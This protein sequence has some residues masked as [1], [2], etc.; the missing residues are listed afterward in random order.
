MRLF[1]VIVLYNSLYWSSGLT[2]ERSSIMSR[3]H[4]RIRTHNRLCSSCV[5]VS[6]VVLCFSFLFF[7]IHLASILGDRHIPIYKLIA[8]QQWDHMKWEHIS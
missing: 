3:I 6:F 4:L 8:T 5:S 2:K 7:F 1:H